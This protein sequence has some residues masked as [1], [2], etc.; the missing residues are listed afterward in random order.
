VPTWGFASSPLVVNDLVVVAA[1]GALAAYEL[2]NGTPRWFGPTG[3]RGYSSPHLATIGGV[4]Q[5]LL[6][7]GE[8]VISVSPTDGSLL[9]KHVW[10]GDS[11][12]QPAVTADGDVLLG[13]GSGLGSEVGMLRIAISQGTNGW[14]TQERWLSAGV[15]PYFNDFVVHKDHAF[16]FDGSNLACID[17]KNG[18]R[19]W[20]GERYGHGQIVLLADQDLILVLSEEGDLALVK[21]T[22]DQF[23][24][25]ARVKAIKGKTWN[26]P[27]LVGD[28]L[29]VRN[30][31]EMAAFRL[32]LGKG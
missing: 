16:G 5:I 12:V 31:E 11:I 26:H 18:E 25:L 23:T 22:S 29:I 32:A 20:K 15:K 28:T 24:E 27:V 3:G 21:A 17:L 14:T 19:R 8:G 30:A 7:N 4:Q 13:S 10:E 2:A 1:S 9:W 6:L